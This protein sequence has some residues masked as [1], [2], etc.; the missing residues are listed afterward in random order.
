[1]NEWKDLLSLPNMLHFSES[2]QWTLIW[3]TGLLLGLSLPLLILEVIQLRKQGALSK[4]RILGMLSNFSL[5]F[6]LVFF[7]SILAA[8]VYRLYLFFSGFQIWQVGVSWWSLLGCLMVID[9]LYYWEHRIVHKVRA[10]WEIFHSV[11]HSGEH[12]DQT[13]G[14]RI[15]FL[16]NLYT[17]FFY[18]PAIVI[19]FDLELVLVCMTLMLTYQQWIHTEWIQKIPGMEGIFNTPSSHRVHHGR[20][21]IYLDKNFGG[22][23]ILWDRLFGT[24]QPETEKVEYGILHPVKS[25]NPLVVLFIG[26]SRLSGK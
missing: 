22:I 15:S 23:L 1:M 11:H 5:F 6:P 19:G 24:Y 3:I 2:M 21:G 25:I 18:L 16:D 20:N 17:P 12:F 8:S 7:Q 26:I 10:L 9:F 13:V 4:Q 14:T